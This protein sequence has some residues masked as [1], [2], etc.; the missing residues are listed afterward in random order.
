M[1]CQKMQYDVRKSGGSLVVECVQGVDCVEVE[2][3][4]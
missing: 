4:G 1:C 2:M 3:F